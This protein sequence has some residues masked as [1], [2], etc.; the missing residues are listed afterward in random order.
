MNAALPIKRKFFGTE[1]IH[2]KLLIEA[3]KVGAA[4]WTGTG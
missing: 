4:L 3:A 2:V 1:S